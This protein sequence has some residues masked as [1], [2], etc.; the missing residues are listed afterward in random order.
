MLQAGRLCGELPDVLRSRRSAHEDLSFE[1][2]SNFNSNTFATKETMIRGRRPVS[3]C[4][5]L[6][7]FSLTHETSLIM[8]KRATHDSTCVCIQAGVGRT[9]NFPHFSCICAVIKCSEEQL[10]PMLQ[11]DR[12]KMTATC[13]TRVCCIK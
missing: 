7:I 3:F 1:T 11:A 8:K 2:R 12:A 4:F 13:F 9:Y 10:Y 5:L 6:F